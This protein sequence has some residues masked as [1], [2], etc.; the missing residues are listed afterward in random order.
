M[1]QFSRQ[2]GRRTGSVNDKITR[3]LFTFGVCRGRCD[4]VGAAGNM[5]N[6]YGKDIDF[7]WYL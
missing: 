5:S 6:G 7:W 4:S 1:V 3:M 2:H